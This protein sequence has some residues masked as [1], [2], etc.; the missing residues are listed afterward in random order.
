MT[1]RKAWSKIV[2]AHGV[3]VRIFE[4]ARGS[5]LYR[6]VVIGGEKDRKSLGHRDRDLAEQQAKDLASALAEAQLLG[7]TGSELTLGQLFAAYRTHALHLVSAARGRELESAMSMFALAWGKDLP[8][9]DVD[10]TRVE[11]YCAA[12]RALQVLP[13]TLR[14]GEEGTRPR[15]WRTPKPPRDGALD[16][17]FRCL[18]AMLNWA[19]GF[20]ISGRPLLR[21][22]P[23]P[24]DG[25]ARR[26]MGWPIEKNPRRPVAARDRYE[27]TQAHTDSV[28]P[29]GRLRC[30]L[31]LA[32]YTAR[33]E[34]AI[35]CLKASDLLLSHARVRVAL[36]SSGLN[37]QD[38][39]HMPFGA[40]RW[41]DDADKQG[42]LFITPINAQMRA[43]LDRYLRL[44]PRMGEVPLFPAPGRTSA[45]DGKQ[46]GERE[47]PFSRHLAAKWLLK[48]EQLAG[49]PKLRGGVFHPYRRLWAIERRHLPAIDVAAAGGWGDTQALTRIYQ[50]AE[51]S[52][53]A[54]VVNLD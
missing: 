15:G 17:E 46:D 7:Y 25:K 44:N 33:R 19:V 2:D 11:G 28:D 43:E 51:V 16:A 49:V 4:R 26:A 23:L 5:V 10:R 40:I 37:E 13:P 41:R 47:A 8:V 42:Y 53:I 1:R 14:A 39:D 45:R 50:R 36:A 6:S 48:A 30:V 18:N 32:R 34:S 38:A 21:G 35:C 22:N 31:A 20:R 24:R 12:R 29:R 54:N 9:V 3:Q 27:V 52:G